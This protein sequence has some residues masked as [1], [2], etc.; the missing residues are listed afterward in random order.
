MV[1]WKADEYTTYL[2]KTA[3]GSKDYED[4]LLQQF[5]PLGDVLDALKA[6]KPLKTVPQSAVFADSD[7]NLLAWSLPGILSG[8]MQVR[9]IKTVGRSSC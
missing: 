7:N 1:T 9:G 6:D 4:K 3:V 8:R 2:K 5:P